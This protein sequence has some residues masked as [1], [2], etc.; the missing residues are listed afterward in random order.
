MIKMNKD[1]K[2]NILI[3]DDNNAN[4]FALEQILEKPNHNILK[5]T[6]GK[7][8]L[9][10]ILDNPIDLIMLDVN[11][12]GMDGFE[13]AKVLKT[14]KRTKDIPI[15]FASAEKIG[16]EF[17]IKG[18]EEG[19]VDYLTKPLDPDITLAKVSVLLKLQ[20]QK[21][22][23]IEKN[24][25]LERYALLI[26]NSADIITII[27]SVSLVFV[28]VNNAVSKIMGY[29][30]DEIKNTTLTDYLAEESKDIIKR[31]QTSNK[32]TLS[33]ETKVFCKD[34]KIKWLNWNV[35]FKNG[36]WFS[37]A[38]DISNEKQVEE[39][40]NYLSAIV[41]QSN[42]AIYLF[43][44]EGKIISWNSGAQKVYGYSE[45]EVMQMTLWDL[46]PDHILHR[47]KKHIK[48]IFAGDKIH[49]VE[50]KRITKNKKIIDVLFSASVITVNNSEIHSAAITER[51][52]TV[53]KILDEEVKQL[54]KDL[55]KNV[56]KLEIANKELE[57]FSYSVSHDLRA[58]LRHIAGFAQLLQMNLKENLDDKTNHCI[59]VINDSAN[60]MGELIDDLLSFSR[61]GRASLN[62]TMVSFNNIIS[63]ILNIEKDE[64]LKRTISVNLQ[65][66]P[67]IKVDINLFRLVWSNLISNAIKYTRKT[68][69][70][71]IDIGYEKKNGDYL[72]YVRDNGAGFDMDYYDKLFGVFQRLHSQ[73]D[74]EGNGI[75]LANVKR[76]IN[77][78]EGKIWATGKINDGAT[79][80]FTI[81]DHSVNK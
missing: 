64:I 44:E 54:N 39:I 79:F 8:A 72:F 77:K 75:G 34:K 25:I 26:N 22:E 65:E 18:Y 35:V 15:I 3:V 29:T 60:Q 20:K 21:N 63:E 81:P 19:A 59:N 2:A 33:F 49:F 37:N 40:K 10:L 17:A 52:I 38:R 71:V 58:P 11:M 55:K 6:D 70:P 53:Q 68:S 62:K 13:V 23:L 51:D 74:F 48:K 5:A 46:I 61:I 7:Q 30:V 31:H 24:Q 16:N 66:L 45:E 47:E 43:N 14:N 57:A 36:L 41:K 69:K 28:E 4:I 67:I 76:I 56:E 50:T 1:N 12:P 80:Y 27:D 42:D 73:S 32:E 9:K 78:H